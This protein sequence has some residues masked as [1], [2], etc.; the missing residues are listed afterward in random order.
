M[1]QPAA[2]PLALDEASVRARVLLVEDDDADAI[3]VEELLVDAGDPFDVVRART[4]REALPL[5]G[6]VDGV[7]ADLGLPDAMGLGAVEQ[8]RRAAPDLPLVVL[9]GTNDRARG[10]AALAAGAQDYLVKGEVDGPALGRAVRYAVQRRRTESNA[11]RLLLVEQ[12]QAENDRLA[13]GLLPRLSV[14]GR[15]VGTATR[16]LPGGEDAL[17]GGD[18]FD[19]VQLPDGSVRAVIGDVCGHGPD[20]AAV[21]VALRIAWRTMVLAG[22]EPAEVLRAVDEMLRHESTEPAL[23]TTVC[24]VTIAPASAIAP[25]T[26]IPPAAAAGASAGSEPAEWA[27]TVRLHGHQP[28]LLV[29]PEVRFLDE[30][31]PSPPLG[32][33][34]YTPAAPFQVPLG[35]RWAMLLATD[36]L[37]EA[38]TERGRLGLTGLADLVAQIPQWH[39]EPDA[40]LARLLHEVIDSNGGSLTDDVALLWLGSVL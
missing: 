13:R 21:G 26:A 37:H 9:T 18:F 11:R 12:R 29:G 1:Q 4:L 35:R 15:G 7:L 36:G 24:D 14:A 33:L 17:L 8:L 27:V 30:G 22:A 39:A 31:P 38:R 32:V 23:F 6:L 40:A 34:T 19:A 10:L 5:L 16:Y 20:E 3:L 25:S 28:P 2:A